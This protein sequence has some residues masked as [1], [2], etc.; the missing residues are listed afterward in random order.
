M[1]APRSCPRCAAPMARLSLASRQPRPVQLDHCA[2]C[3]HVWF[4]PLESVQLAGLGWLQLLRAMRGES[5]AAAPTEQPRCP[6]CGDALKTVHNRT[7]FGRFP[8]LECAR[9]HGHLAGQAALLAERGLLRALLPHDRATLAGEGRRLL[10]L[11]C[12]APAAA[13]ADDCAHCGTPLRLLDL[14]RLAHALTVESADA[15]ASPRGGAALMAW[16]CRG[17]GR[18]L[19]PVTETTCPSCQH[20][21][22][23]GGLPDLTGL[24]DALEPQL[25]PPAPRPA[26]PPRAPRPADHRNT[27]LWRVGDLVRTDSQGPWP[28]LGW[29]W[30]VVALLLLGAWIWF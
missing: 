14:P 30:V 17:C 20:T 9:G 6:D 1:T 23:V 13:S 24:L 28:G 3:H 8:G 21:V 2:A 15:G 5:T 25:T 18:P 16:P 7:R 11:Q 22:V 4:D 19:D 27:S 26:P 12:G 10:C 29:P